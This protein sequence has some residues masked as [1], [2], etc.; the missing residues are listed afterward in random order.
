MNA[1]NASTV[2]RRITP[3][4]RNLK[5]GVWSIA[6]GLA[7]AFAVYLCAPRLI[8]LPEAVVNSFA[9][10]SMA[11]PL[12]IFAAR[13]LHGWFHLPSR[14]ELASLMNLLAWCF[15]GLLLALS[16]LA[17]FIGLD[18]SLGITTPEPGWALMGTVIQVYA[19]ELLFRGVL[20]AVLAALILKPNGG[21]NLALLLSC[22]LFS[23]WH[24]PSGP[25]AFL[26]HLLFAFLMLKLVEIYGGLL[27]P[28]AFHVTNNLF[29]ILV[30]VSG[31][32]LSALP[33]G[34]LELIKYAVWA[35]V[36]YAVFRGKTQAMPGTGPSRV[37]INSQQ[38]QTPRLPAIDAL[39]GVALGIIMIENLMLY[40]PAEHMITATSESDKAVRAAV[41]LFVEFR[42]LPLFC[43]LLGFGV[44]VIIDHYG[45]AWKLHMRLRNTAFLVLGTVH[46]LWIFSGD[47]LAIYAVALAIFGLMIRRRQA[48]GLGKI[49]LAISLY[50]LYILVLPMTL[51]LVEFP[52]SVD[53][54][55]FSSSWDGAQA[56]RSAEWVSSMAVSP[57]SAGGVLLPMAIGYSSAQRVRNPGRLLN[58][59][60]S[61]W[62]ICLMATS[63]LLSIPYASALLANWGSAGFAAA[64]AWAMIPA[65]IGGLCG[66]VSLWMITLRLSIKER[67]CPMP[68]WQPCLNFL[69]PCGSSS[70]SGYLLHSVLFLLFLPPFALGLSTL[71]LPVLIS[72]VLGLWFLYCGL[73]SNF[74]GRL[75]PAERFMKW[76]AGRPTYRKAE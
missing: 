7:L 56:T 40:M 19:E 12:T 47:I 39:R 9:I 29:G 31:P 60:F 45:P 18:M 75:F 50:L 41:A 57:L 54:S 17:R 23:L 71:P 33:A 6:A 32:G 62:S 37:P 44:R 13:N 46:G 11:L 34:T 25:V 20:P 53:N 4:I 55:Y 58:R 67:T 14:R 10:G 43:I 1:P 48:L 59:R 63:V 22:V 73:T 49:T 27:A 3:D 8:D 76:T 68:R 66:A 69:A 28:V 51:M 70:L 26:D 38:A 15:T 52:A 2:S 35:L 72:A 65:Q 21:S 74:K 16:L 5:S 24:L 42:G 36:L 64:G 30:S 61:T